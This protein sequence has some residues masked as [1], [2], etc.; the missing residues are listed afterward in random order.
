[1]NYYFKTYKYILSV[2]AV[3]LVAI[4]QPLSAQSDNKVTVPLS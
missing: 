2:A 1:M 4:A 3:V